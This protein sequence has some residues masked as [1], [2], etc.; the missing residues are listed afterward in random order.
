M[1]ALASAEAKARLLELME[2]LSLSYEK[3][4]DH[5]LEAVTGSL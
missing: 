3:E 5:N 4:L 2:S 1:R